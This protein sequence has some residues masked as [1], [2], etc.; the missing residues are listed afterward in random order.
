MNRPTNQWPVAY[1][2]FVRNIQADQ[3]SRF[4]WYSPGLER[5]W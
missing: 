1:C 2:T 3:T 5:D 4:D